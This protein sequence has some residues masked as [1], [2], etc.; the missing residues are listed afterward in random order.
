[1]GML[2]HPTHPA[3]MTTKNEQTQIPF[4]LGKTFMR[5]SD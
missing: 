1:M 4:K 5:Q 2:P 3:A